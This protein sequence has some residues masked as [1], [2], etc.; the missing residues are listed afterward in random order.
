MKQYD[1]I[2]VATDEKELS[3]HFIAGGMWQ[4]RKDVIVT[5]IEELREMWD[6]AC[7]LIVAI[8]TNGTT[9][10]RPNFHEYLN[11]KGIKP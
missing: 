5:T 2:M 11:S 8:N 7:L 1:Q 6:A 4:S 10:G 9:G 3:P